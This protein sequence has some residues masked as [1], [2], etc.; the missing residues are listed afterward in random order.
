MK[1]HVRHGDI[2]RTTLMM[3]GLG[4]K[5]ADTVMAR[6][7]NRTLTSVRAQCARKIG[8]DITPK[9]STIKAHIKQ[10]KAYKTNPIGWLECSG[11]PLNLIH[12]RARQTKKGITVQVKKNK[13]RALL[14]HAFIADI[15]GGKV[16][17][18]D[19]RFSGTTQSKKGPQV[20]WRKYSGPRKPATPGRRYAALPYEYRWPLKNLTGPR[21]PDI[22]AD[23]EV[24]I[25][26]LADAKDKLTGNL[27]H[28]IDFMLDKL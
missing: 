26:I 1:A 9:I 18:N 2:T 22:L 21:I 15:G 4:G 16:Y 10:K 23:D 12:Y 14:R 19:P 13:P 27:K 25:P 6:A 3:M 20:Y 7:V 28:E 5:K 24:M 11:R 17:R 8:E